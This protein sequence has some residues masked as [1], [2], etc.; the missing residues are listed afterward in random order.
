MLALDEAQ[1]EWWNAQVS[2]DITSFRNPIQFVGNHR[3]QHEGDHATPTIC[4]ETM[5]LA[6]RR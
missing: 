4:C 1:L 3:H 6:N 2:A 5:A